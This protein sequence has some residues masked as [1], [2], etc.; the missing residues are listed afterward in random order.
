MRFTAVRRLVLSVAIIGAIE[1]AYMLVVAG[2]LFGAP[3]DPEV[4]RAAAWTSMGIEVL[5]VTSLFVLGAAVIRLA[6]ARRRD[7]SRIPR[8]PLFAVA[9]M[10]AG[11][12]VVGVWAALE[13]LGTGNWFGGPL[14]V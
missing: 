14:S 1:V 10:N 4:A 8:W 11:A 9:F 5:L 13:E 3:A 12:V 7:G 2:I 6:A